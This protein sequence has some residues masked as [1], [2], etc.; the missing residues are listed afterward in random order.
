[1]GTETFK[2]GRR[3]RL[4]LG[5]LIR[6]CWYYET[7][8]VRPD[9][10][11]LRAI[12]NAIGYFKQSMGRWSV[13]PYAFT[14]NKKRDPDGMSFYREDFVSA[15]SVSDNNG[16]PAGVRVARI[17]AKELIELGLTIE[18][19]VIAE[20]LPG[21][22]IVPGMRHVEARPKPEK[23]KIKDLSQQLAK[24]ASDAIVYIPPGMGD[25]SPSPPP[26]S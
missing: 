19:S 18:P 20:D 1:L 2:R 6:W 3:S 9:E 23:L 16:Y 5:N 26:R 17:K 11:L 15:K 7:C 25:P 8:P 12:P 4:R 10:F 21:H 22:V 14:P 24:L 13:D